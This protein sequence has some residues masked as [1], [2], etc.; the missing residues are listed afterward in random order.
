MNIN[1]TPRRPGT[2]LID[3]RNVLNK[4]NSVVKKKSKQKVIQMPPEWDSV[5][6]N[7]YRLLVGPK[8]S[9]YMSP[10]P[11]SQEKT[12]TPTKKNAES[13]K[14]EKILSRLAPS[15]LKTP[16]EPA[17][18][19][20]EAVDACNYP[21][22]LLV[23][24]VS[25]DQ[26]RNYNLITK[27]RPKTAIK[28]TTHVSKPKSNTLITPLSDEGKIQDFDQN[29]DTLKLYR[30]SS[31]I[32][33]NISSPGQLTN[34]SS[35][36]LLKS[37]ESFNLNENSDQNQSSTFN[38][39]ESIVQTES[40]Q[41]IIL[42][43]AHSETQEEKTE[44]QNLLLVEMR[45]KTKT[46]MFFYILR[47]WACYCKNARLKADFIEEVNIYRILNHLVHKWHFYTQ[48]K[49]ILRQ[50]HQL[51]I[52]THLHQLFSS[53]F[54][55]WKRKAKKAIKQATECCDF[56]NRINRRI[57]LKVISV[58]HH[59]A[60]SKRLCRREVYLNFRYNSKVFKTI[61]SR[62][63]ID[64]KFKLDPYYAILR[65]K[66]TNAMNFH[67]HKVV[68]PCIKHW[69]WAVNRGKSDRA[70]IE[71]V[72]QMILIITFKRWF[73]IFQ[74]TFHSRV[75]IEVRRV[76]AQFNEMQ[77]RLEEE[78]AQHLDRSVIIQ[79]QRDKE[80][81]E[82]KIAQFDQ[83]SENH[84]QAV[85]RRIQIREEIKETTNIY[86]KRQEELTLIDE[87]KIEDD[88][89][90][91]TN[92]IR[93]QLAEAFLYH[94]A[95]AV[96]SFENQ[97]VAQE[98]CAC[99]RILSSPIVNKAVGYFYEKKQI[100]ELLKIFKKEQKVI[101]TAVG[102]AK[103]YHE[104]FGWKSWRRFMKIINENRSPGI[105]EV[106]R[107]RA[108]I[109]QYFPYFNWVEVLPVRP[110]RPLK[111]IESMFKDLPLVS[112]QRKVARERVHHVNVRM[113]LARRRVL[114][115]FIRAFAS[116]VQERIATREVLILIKRRRD[117]DKLRIGMDAF[118]LNKDQ[119]FIFRNRMNQ[120][121][122]GFTADIQAWLRNFFRVKA[123]L[124]QMND[125]VEVSY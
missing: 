82:K 10:Q 25:P 80:I 8:V 125:E 96:R 54:Q 124:K 2:Q 5:T 36:A 38:L 65:P 48:S 71:K 79:L 123:K 37:H 20:V 109:L 43:E 39:T 105:I 17:Q 44:K 47:C 76:S 53:S 6:A 120:I 94:M 61:G 95:R 23:Q 45:Q 100:I 91:R 42:I 27:P 93:K 62:S 4:I 28:R 112:V 24:I 50:K 57:L 14:R 52:N 3:N 49:K 63:L 51:L 15:R 117:M 92:E 84:E 21:N 72:H 86:F 26:P 118:K 16:Y 106:I 12:T 19:T 110:P 34:R 46:R 107:R 74:Q 113:M 33:E 85:T 56:L 31:R 11:T 75:L 99:F 90:K 104:N 119:T 7:A 55:K 35:E 83:L 18:I 101:K 116:Y 30:S 88:I 9:Q 97:I 102:C 59:I 69:I 32:S 70:S 64:Q 41:Q 89:N 114:R 73:K 108:T 77:F 40:Q 29:S 13:S 87:A 66:L 98:Y 68:S 115:D 111:E 67:F 81:L 60:H 122:L 78:I 58:F 1:K 121:Q 103:L 22:D